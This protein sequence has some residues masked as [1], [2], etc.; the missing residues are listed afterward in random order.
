MSSPAKAVWIDV[1]MW[2]G[3]S[4]KPQ[5]YIDIECEP[6][7]KAPGSADA[8]QEWA[9]AHLAQIAQQDSWQPGRHYF[10]VEQRDPSGRSIESYAHGIWEWGS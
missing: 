8:W 2:T 5:P 7:R 3:L 10:T 4:G 9:L 1:S 6:P